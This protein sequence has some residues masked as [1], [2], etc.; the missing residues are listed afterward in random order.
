MMIKNLYVI[1]VETRHGVSLHE[2]DILLSHILRKP[3]EFVY[4]H[5]TYQ[6]TK[7]QYRKFQ[8]LVKRRE[9]G[10]P[11]AYLTGHKEF[12]GLDF[13]VNRHVLIPRP[14]TETLIDAVL[15]QL[16]PGQLVCDVGTGSGNIAIT[17]KKLRSDIT[18][19]AT[20]ISVKALGVAKKNSHKQK[21]KITFYKSDVLRDVPKKYYGKID[22]LI[23]NAPYLTKREASKPSLCYEPRL[24]LTPTNDA[25]SLIKKLLKQSPQFLSPV[26]RIVLEIGHNQAERIKKIT[27]K[28]YPRCKVT[29]IKDYA[30]LDRVVVIC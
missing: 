1:S 5:P 3:K 26:G 6:L 25:V 2:V 27:Q 18:V 12:Y 14:D 19:I 21:T 29:I 20:D 15:P 16:K 28:I 17:L 9:Q 13:M 24:A 7:P 8:T 10:E 4:A 22:W 23:C 30:Q 11:I